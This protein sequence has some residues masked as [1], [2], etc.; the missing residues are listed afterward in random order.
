[1]PQTHNTS[2]AVR[3]LQGEIQGLRKDRPEGRR[4]EQQAAHCGSPQGQAPAGLKA[5]AAMPLHRQ[6]LHTAWSCQEAPNL[7]TQGLPGRR[8]ANCPSPTQEQEELP[9]DLSLSSCRTHL[10]M[11]R[12]TCAAA[13]LLSTLPKD[14]AEQSPSPAHPALYPRGHRAIPQ[15]SY[16]YPC[17]GLGTEQ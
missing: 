12:A 16:H 11:A 1:M 15:L 13:A 10:H 5:A 8:L 17:P 7:G 6:H 9:T 14:R 2:V 4:L 3:S